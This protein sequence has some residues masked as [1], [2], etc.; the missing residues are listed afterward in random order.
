[1]RKQGLPPSTVQE[2]HVDGLIPGSSASLVNVVETLQDLAVARGTVT[3]TDAATA[4]ELLG[5]RKAIE[6]LQVQSLLALPLTEGND[7]IGVI[8]LAQNTSRAWKPAEVVVLKTL[9]DQVV[10]ALNNAGLRRLVKNLSVTDEKS[11]LLKRASYLDLLQ[12]ETRRGLQQGTAV[13]VLLMNFG[14]RSVLTKEY[15][16]QAVD[17]TMQQI[18]Q[19]FSANIRTND[20]AFRYQAT[21]VALILGDTGEK[22][23]LLAVEKLRRLLA[24]VR[25]SPKA[26]PV[27]FSAGLAQAVMKQHFDPVDIVTEVVNRAD[28][29]LEQAVAQGMGKIVCQAPQFAA[30]AAVA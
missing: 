12:A 24:E 15:G 8:V 7:Q 2:Y 3:I 20:L 28:V 4:P 21:T 13:T 27:D 16:E 30:S 17:A 25:F 23:A 26:S 1:M 6:E 5:I 22:E 29:A 11:G 18:G 10:I 9:T 14:R 19:L